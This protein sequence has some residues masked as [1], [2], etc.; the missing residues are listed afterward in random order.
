MSR[1]VLYIIFYI[2]LLA[3]PVFGQ[4]EEGVFD[5]ETYNLYDKAYN[6]NESKDYLLAYRN[7]LLADQSVLTTLS[8]KHLKASSLSD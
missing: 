6:L 1:R 3:T 8:K 5:D 2:S 4:Q 7:I